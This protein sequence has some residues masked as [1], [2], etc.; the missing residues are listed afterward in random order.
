MGSTRLIPAQYV[1]GSHRQLWL[2]NY[3]SFLIYRT[4]LKQLEKITASVRREDNQERLLLGACEAHGGLLLLFTL[5]N[6]NVLPLNVLKSQFAT[7]FC[8]AEIK[9]ESTVSRVCKI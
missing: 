4:R 2:S 5:L 9:T 6:G 1:V 8:Q 7:D 3:V